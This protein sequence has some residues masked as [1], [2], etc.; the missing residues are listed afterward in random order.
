[1][2]A[3]SALALAA[4]AT[5]AEAGP[6]RGGNHEERYER[7]L[8][9]MTKELN[10]TPEQQ[11]KIKKLHDAAK[12]EMK[13]KKEAMKKAAEEFEASLQGSETGEKIRAQFSKLQAAQDEFA[14][15]RLEK[16]LS[17]REVL[18]PE[19]RK[20]FKGMGPR[21]GFKDGMGWG[22]KGHRGRGGPKGPDEAEDDQ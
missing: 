17:V 10:L 4:A 11:E 22:H 13:S 8:A 5:K 1:M 21:H 18:T 9:K 14:K 15:A 20:N 12:D 7:H 16:I 19:Q 6:G 3:L 2:A